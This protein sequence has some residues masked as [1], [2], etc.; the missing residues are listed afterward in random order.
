MEHT[1]LRFLMIGAH[2]DD[3]ELRCGGLAMRMRQ[4][5][6]AVKFLSMTDGSAGHLTDDRE[7]L[8]RRR[9]EE[10]SAAARIFDVDYRIMPFPDGELEVNLATRRALMAEIRSFA[11]HVIITHRTVD[12]HPDH[13]ACGQLVMDCSFLVNVPHVFPE[14]P[15]PSYAPVILSLI[16]PFAVPI[17]F[18][19]DLAVPIDDY[20]ERKIEGCLCHVSQFYEWLPHIENWPE[21]RNAATFEEKTKL[22]VELLRHRFTREVQR[23]PQMIPA[24]TQYAELYQIDEYGAPLTEELRRE[25]TGIY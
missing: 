14:I 1:A 9:K 17:P 8:A 18:R 24:G 20:V 13:R 2:P 10:A 11:P 15:A 23:Y 7:T 4:R 25:I 6:H 12:Y 19:A 21:I 3:L 16:D 5:G 22:L